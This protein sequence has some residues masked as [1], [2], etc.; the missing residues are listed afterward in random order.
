MIRAR[1][2][3]MDKR[4]IVYV[5]RKITSFGDG[6]VEQTVGYFVSQAYLN[7]AGKSYDKDGTTSCVYYVDFVKRYFSEDMQGLELYV[8]CG[9]TRNEFKKNAFKDYQSCKECVYKLNQ[10]EAEHLH[11]WDKTHDSKWLLL[12]MQALEM[13]EKLENKYITVEGR[14]KEKN[15]NNIKEV[16]L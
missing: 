3:I 5:P 2:E 6:S 12:H 9:D 8:E 16:K 10:W 14:E 13:A 4:P 1:R 7:Y 15:T 11:R